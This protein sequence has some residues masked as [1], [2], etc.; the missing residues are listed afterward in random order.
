MRFRQQPNPNGIVDLSHGVLFATVLIALLFIVLLYRDDIKQRRLQNEAASRLNTSFGSLA[1]PPYAQVDDIVPGF[2]ALSITGR[3]ADVV[4]SGHAK[5]LFFMFSSE[6][7]VCRSEI[8]RWKFIV[9]RAGSNQII[10]L[11]L[12]A[13]SNPSALPD[14]GFDAVLLSDTSVRRAYRMVAVPATMLVS[15]HGRIEWVHYGGLTDEG[16]AELLSK[17]TVNSRKD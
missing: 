11:G 17:L 1:G 14:L 12:I 10:P 4:Y 8:P 5:Y 15:E 16:T 13:N 2:E 6:C 7:D 9:S 3:R